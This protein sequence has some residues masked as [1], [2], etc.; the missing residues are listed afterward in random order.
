MK[1]V[2]IGFPEFLLAGGITLC[3]LVPGTLAISLTSLSILSAMFRASLNIN[4]LNK[5][6]ERKAAEEERR[7][8]SEDRVNKIIDQLV[9]SNQLHAAAQAHNILSGQFGG[10]SD[11]GN[12]G[13]HH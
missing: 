13:T 2:T 11:G 10:G 6:E 4:Y 9:T 7:I 8:Q 3:V 12:N 1:S 5:D